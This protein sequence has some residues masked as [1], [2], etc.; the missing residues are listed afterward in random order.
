MSLK[1]CIAHK[2]IPAQINTEF[3]V[4]T[5][6]IDQAENRNTTLQAYINTTY[7]YNCISSIIVKI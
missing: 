5:E 6:N 1:M 3:A 7:I 2:F 4:V